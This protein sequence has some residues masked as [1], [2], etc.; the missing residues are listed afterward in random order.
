M[1]S[2][3]YMGEAPEQ[4]TPF[5]LSPCFFHSTPCK[6]PRLARPASEW[7]G[8]FR[9]PGPVKTEAES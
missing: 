8:L 4:P 2:S 6:I 5:D 9:S 1:T 7:G 3:F